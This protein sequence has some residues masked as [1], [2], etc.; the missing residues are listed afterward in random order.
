MPTLY[1]SIEAAEVRCSKPEHC[2]NCRKRHTWFSQ[3]SKPVS[4]NSNDVREMYWQC[5]LCGYCNNPVLYNNKHS[6][7]PLLTM[8]QSDWML[9]QRWE[10]ELTLKSL[11]LNTG[12]SIDR[13]SDIERRYDA[14]LPEEWQKIKEILGCAQN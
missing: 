8:E 11:S 13:L 10:R 14:P 12:I 1:P 2:K 7:Y 9:D 5:D 6:E 3:N 4:L